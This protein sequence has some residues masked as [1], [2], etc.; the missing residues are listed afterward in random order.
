LAR[1]WASCSLVDQPCSELYG[2]GMA[3]SLIQF[4]DRVAIVTGAG[5]GLGRE[6]ALF[7]AARGAKVVVN[8]SSSEHATATANDI[9]QRGG[10][11]IP[12]THSVAEPDAASAIIKTALD[13]FGAL[14]IVLNNAGRGGPTGTIEQTTDQQVATII[15]THLVGSYNVSRAAWAHF[16]QQRFGRILMTS[17]S[18]AIGSLGMP[19]YSMAKAGL[20][21]LARSLAL[22]GAADNILVNVLMPIGYT[23]SAALNPNEDT[24][25]W[26]EDN[27]GPQMC[28]PAAAWLVHDD[29]PCSGQIFTTGAGRT[30]LIST[31]GIPG[32][33][34][35]PDATIEGLRD[36]WSEVVDPTGSVPMTYSRDDLRFYTGPATWR[37]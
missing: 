24:R 25:K 15:S 12:D 21:G 13:E 20:I 22:E 31:M 10:I 35:G 7:L 29:V 5:R 36:H 18:A 8:D 17:S 1:H 37:D 6:H 30:A 16:R 28:S 11:A 3:E 2:G 14:H 27:F 33:S 9:V 34:G 4:N 23:R 19:A 32:W 26:M